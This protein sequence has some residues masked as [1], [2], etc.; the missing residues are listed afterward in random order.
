LTSPKKLM[1]AH[2]AP[3]Q[4]L[5]VI[6]TS[7]IGLTATG[8]AQ[9]DA[10][11]LSGGVNTLATTGASTGVKLPPCEAGAMCVVNNMG[12]STLTVYPFETAGVT[13]DGTTSAAIATSRGAIFFGTGLDW[14]FVYGA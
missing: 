2:F 1:G 11:Q 3:L 10:L 8:S 7:A 14:A 12:A 6:G 9:T 4:A 5:E 13:V